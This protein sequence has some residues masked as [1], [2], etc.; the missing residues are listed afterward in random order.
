MMTGELSILFL[1]NAAKR[2]SID[3]FSFALASFCLE[4]AARLCLQGFRA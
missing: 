2:G 3:G 4:T 1:A